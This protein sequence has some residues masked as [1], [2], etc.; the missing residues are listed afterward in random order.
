M[1]RT[2]HA[3][4][5]TCAE[6][7][8]QFGP[9]GFHEKVSAQFLS[10]PSNFQD[11]VP[12]CKTDYL[13]LFAPRCRRCSNPVRGRF[14]TALGAAWDPECFVCQVWSC[15][16]QAAQHSAAWDLQDCSRPFAS[17]SFFELNGIPLCEQHIHERRGSVC[18][19]CRQPI[20]GRCVLALGQKYHPEH[21]T[22]S[23][24]GRAVNRQNYKQ[25][26]NRC[27]CQ[28]CFEK[29]NPSFEM[30]SD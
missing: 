15:G 16:S 24:C 19:Q 28:R 30:L 27:I 5:F 22:C 20:V 2:Y 23:S 9:E 10:P 11:G 6:C 14:I 18:A 29:V 4:H 17:G 3:E 21:F 13:R 7:N 8:C 1:N 12:Y 25:L 26:N